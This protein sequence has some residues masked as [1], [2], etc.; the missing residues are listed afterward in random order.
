MLQATLKQRIDRDKEFVS[1]NAG[2]GVFLNMFQKII[3]II[4]IFTVQAVCAFS[5]FMKHM[6][7]YILCSA[8]VI[9]NIMCRF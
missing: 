6:C 7:Y 8:D 2:P 3:K 9:N 1:S 4:I 5:V